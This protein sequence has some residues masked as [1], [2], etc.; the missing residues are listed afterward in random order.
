ML[1]SFQTP[2]AKSV[3]KSRSFDRIC[4]VMRKPISRDGMEEEK[5]FKATKKKRKKGGM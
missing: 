2:S 1:F 3:T 4:D 5:K